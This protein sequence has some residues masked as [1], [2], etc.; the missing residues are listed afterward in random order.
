LGTAGLVLSALLSAEV[1][2]GA[3]VDT[4][5]NDVGASEVWD[6][7]R[8]LL[9]IWL[10]SVTA[11]T[12]EIE[13]LREAFVGRRGGFAI[14]AEKRASG[15][16]LLAPEFLQRRSNCIRV[17]TWVVLAG[18]SSSEEQARSDHSSSSSEVHFVYIFFSGIVKVLRGRLLCDGIK[19]VVVD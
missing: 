2:S 18:N 7:L 1:C 11:D 6:G 14:V 17:E 15:D 10:F 13:V 19:R 16:L 8:V 4:S 5:L 9:K 3:V 12:G